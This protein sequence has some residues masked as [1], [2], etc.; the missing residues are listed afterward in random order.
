MQIKNK[1]QVASNKDTGF[2]QASAYR[3]PNK[4]KWK[5]TN[6]WKSFSNCVF[7]FVSNGKIVHRWNIFRTKINPKSQNLFIANAVAY[8]YCSLR[9]MC[10]WKS[11][12]VETM[13]SYVWVKWPYGFGFACK[14]DLNRTAFF[15]YSL[16]ALLFSPTKIHQLKQ[17]SALFKRKAAHTYNKTYECYKYIT[18]Q[19]HALI[20]KRKRFL[21]R[22]LAFLEIRIMTTSMEIRWK[23][24][25]RFDSCINLRRASEWS[26]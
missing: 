11:Y 7:C 17:H 26:K 6:E 12:S 16:Y 10:S 25:P 4:L 20:A 14:T 15:Q 21:R 5:K 9:Y 18:V 19:V 24:S 23:F 1:F 8:V 2:S 13:K 22:A 3:F